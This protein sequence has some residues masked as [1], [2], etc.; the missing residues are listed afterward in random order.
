MVLSGFVK[1]ESPLTIYLIL[2]LHL[3]FLEIVLII[4]LIFFLSNGAV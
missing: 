4:K 2:K 1:K 3:F